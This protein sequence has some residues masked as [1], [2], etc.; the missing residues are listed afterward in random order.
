MKKRNIVLIMIAVIAFLT[1]AAASVTAQD[2]DVENMDNSDLMALLQAILQKLKDDGSEV[3]PAEGS[4]Q[5]AV[6]GPAEEPAPDP[7][8]FE[9][10]KNKKL[11]IE[12]L[13]EYMFIR[14][15]ADKSESDSS[16]HDDKIWNIIQKVFEND[17][18]GV[19]SM[20]GFGSAEDLYNEWKDSDTN[21]DQYGSQVDDWLKRH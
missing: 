6:T 18:Q 11:T 9:V 8:R 2:I 4:L 1:V 12:H 19:R 16:S 5:S 14:K 17:Y 7:G 20:L 10:Y 21:W 3:L 15:P 13:P